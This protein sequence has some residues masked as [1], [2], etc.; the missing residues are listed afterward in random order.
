MPITTIDVVTNAM[1]GVETAKNAT[2]IV[3][4][5]RTG[6]YETLNATFEQSITYDNLEDKYT[7][8]FY[9]NIDSLRTVDGGSP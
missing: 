9:N 5:M 6:S 8:R 4:C 3:Y 7:Y 2:A 1:S